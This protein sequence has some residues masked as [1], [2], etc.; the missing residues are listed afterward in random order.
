MKFLI[1]LAL[2]VAVVWAYYTGV[3]NFSREEVKDLARKTEEKAVAV[4][5]AIIVQGGQ[6]VADRGSARGI[7]YDGSEDS[8]WAADRSLLFLKIVDKDLVKN[9]NGSIRLCGR[10]QNDSQSSLKFISISAVLINQG[11]V[12]KGPSF[13]I[14]DLS[15]SLK[16]GEALPF[17]FFFR[18]P[19]PF[20]S[21][22]FKIEEAKFFVDRYD[23]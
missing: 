22:K 23:K 6:G 16:P 8:S 10:L 18:D 5:D 4:F 19:P 7:G 9:P 15:K 14:R 3:I 17:D 21:F 20:T 13:F 11:Q 1:L 2:I 12:V